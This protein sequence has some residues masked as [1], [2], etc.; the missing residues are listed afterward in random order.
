[1]F[2][3]RRTNRVGQLVGRWVGNAVFRKGE[4][5]MPDITRH[6]VIVGAGMAGLTAAAYLARAGLKPLL[7]EKNAEVG[8]LVGSF[9]RDGF[10]FDAGVRALEDAGIIL[11][12]LKELRIP[13]ETL[14]SPVSLGLGSE[15]LHLEG[16]GILG[17]Y[18]DFLKK[19]YPASAG[20]IDA[21]L[22]IIR[23]IMRLMDVL[24]GVENPLFKDLP[25]EP[26]FVFK[27][28]LPW[29]P[30]FLFA[31][32]RINRLRLPVE[33]YLA[34]R[35]SDPALRDI[36]AQHFFQNTPTF[37]A[38]SYFSLYLDYFYPRGG[39]GSLAQGLRERILALG[40]EIETD[41]AISAVDPIKHKVTDQAGRGWGYQ[42]L[43]WA[44]DLKTLYR[45]TDA[46][47]LPPKS[48][49]GFEAK[50]AELLAH[51][52]GESVFTLFLEVDEAPQTFGRIARG[53]FFYTPSSKGLGA[54]HRDELRELL[55]DFPQLKK[56]EILAWLDRFIA[57]NTFEISIP[58]LKD[59]ALAP[60]G[61]TGIIVSFLARC[62]LFQ[63]VQEAGWLAEFVGEIEERLVKTLSE[64]V[65][66]SLRDKLLARWSFSPL[67]V[68]QRVGSDEGAIVGWEFGPQMPVCDRI[69]NAAQAVITPLPD[70]YQAGQWSYSPAGVPMAILTGRLAANRVLKAS[71]SRI[72]K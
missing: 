43:I 21:L 17:R 54:T 63:K 65:F 12:M 25:R 61:Q 6:T 18:G 36:I 1:M 39:L 47:S 56:Q 27:K 33:R 67:N 59:P 23:R 70:I 7:L 13:L 19:F 55:R 37:F 10:V 68:R 58:A 60:P 32:R 45:I 15:I 3:S 66:P 44:A 62:E 46:D 48:R 28:L 69:Q 35:L 20:E 2:S 72:N 64:S 9:T 8:G 16:P 5:Y 49:R 57:L 11:P 29:L 4:P 26:A 71:K 40:G 22:K 24:Y 34:A 51:R 41:T 38:L 14:P 30:R 52:G 53:H 50:Q 42:N 31:I